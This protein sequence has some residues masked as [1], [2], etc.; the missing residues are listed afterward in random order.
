MLKNKITKFL[1][2]LVISLAFVAWLIFKV[3][4]K[5]TLFYLQRISFLDIVLYVSILLI[6]MIISAYKWK[7]LIE[8]KGFSVSLKECFS[9]YITGS[10]INI[11]FPSIIGGDTYRAYEIGRKTKKYASAVASVVMDRAT[12]FL[13]VMILTIIFSAIN[14]QT[15]SKN[16]L[17]VAINGII[18]LGLIMIPVLLKIA[19]SRFW[20]NF[21]PYVP[22]KIAN[23]LKDFIEYADFRIFLKASLISVIYGL[24]GIAGLNFILFYGLGINI[25]LLDYLSVI[26]LISIVI[27]LPIS[28]NNIGIKEWAYITFFGFFGLAASPVV[29]VALIS[30]LLQML[31]SCMAL[32]I[33]L[34]NKNN[35]KTELK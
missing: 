20:K 14:W 5:E 19:K 9:L 3:D 4:W 7:I 24:V 13:G 33:Y 31:V 15:V 23:I 17:L 30:R 35:I 34:K 22:D 29:T 2:K 25:N 11:F 1:L 10:L 8:F 18:L 6:G 26:F 21:S 32:P 28:I 12:G 27:V 16:S